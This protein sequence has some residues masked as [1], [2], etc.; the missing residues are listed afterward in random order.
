MSD[1]TVIVG[2]IVLFVIVFTM[3]VVL[4]YLWTSK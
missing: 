4:G 3:G 2:V 1:T